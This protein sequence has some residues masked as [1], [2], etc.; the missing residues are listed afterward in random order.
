MTLLYNEVQT[1]EIHYIKT[2]IL[3]L[4]QFNKDQDHLKSINN[5]IK[6]INVKHQFSK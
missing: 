4:H 2:N 1:I 3:N 6:L 5:F